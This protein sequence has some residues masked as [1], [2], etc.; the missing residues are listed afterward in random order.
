MPFASAGQQVV[1]LQ[2]EL[3]RELADRRVA[4]VDQLAAVLGDLAVG[5]RAAE[6]PAAAADPVRGLVYLRDDAGLLQR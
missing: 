1:E 2:P 5:E 3:G 6:R 4:L